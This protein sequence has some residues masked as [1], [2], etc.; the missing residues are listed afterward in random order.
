MPI[1]NFTSLRL[2]RRA[3]AVVLAVVVACGCAVA[4]EKSFLIEFKCQPTTEND[5]AIVD[6]TR[7]KSNP[8]RFISRGYELVESFSDFSKIYRDRTGSGWLIGDL[9]PDNST[10]AGGKFTTNFAESAQVNATRIEISIIAKNTAYHRCYITLNNDDSNYYSDNPYLKA[11]EIHTFS[12]DVKGIKLVNLLLKNY[13]TDTKQYKPYNLTAIR[14][15]YDDGEEEVVTD[16]EMK[17]GEGAFTEAGTDF[18]CGE[19]RLRFDHM[20]NIVDGAALFNT[21][22]RLTVS[23]PEGYFL[24][25]VE[26]QGASAEGSI[27]ASS[28]SVTA[29]KWLPAEGDIALNAVGFTAGSAE[30]LKGVKISYLPFRI[31]HSQVLSTIDFT[32]TET[33]ANSINIHSSFANS[34][35]SSVKSFIIRAN[36]V[37]IAETQPTATE[38][39]FTGLPYLTDGRLTISP[40]IGSTERQPEL[41]E[42]TTLPNLGATEYTIS[43]NMLLYTPRADNP[44]LCDVGGVIRLSLPEDIPTDLYSNF[45]VTVTDYP[46]AVIQLGES[47]IDIYIPTYLEGIPYVD[48][49]PDFSRVEFKPFT[50]SFTPTYQFQVAEVYRGLLTVPAAKPLKANVLSEDISVNLDGDGIQTVTFAE[51]QLQATFTAD[52]EVSAIPALA[53]DPADTTTHYYTLQGIEIQAADLTPGLYIQRRGQRSTLYRHS[54]TPALP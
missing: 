7:I 41:L 43:A 35:K 17:T 3:I 12:F 50:V 38:A 42:G 28:G 48:N 9:N 34:G 23:A 47:F 5:Y 11:G 20:V 19:G 45:Q 30:S 10:S 33:T 24:A 16:P 27:S 8:S 52:T 29:G 21:D 25:A 2:W 54:L 40:V 32:A 18:S 26:F 31:D 1:I 51:Q 22:N 4:A 39:S 44:N 37:Q 36:G 53:A 14:V 46:D 49:R 6:N 15:F 13:V